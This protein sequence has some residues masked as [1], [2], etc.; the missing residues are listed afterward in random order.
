MQ[1]VAKMMRPAKAVE[2]PAEPPPALPKPAP[3]TQ[4]AAPPLPQAAPR[5]RVINMRA[6]INR[7][8][9]AAG[10]RKQD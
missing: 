5:R 4:Q 1:N 8:L 2:T 9:V 6:A 3:P 7:V 10:L